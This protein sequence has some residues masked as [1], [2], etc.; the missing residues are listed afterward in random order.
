MD[1]LSTIERMI[2]LLS[3]EGAWTQ[4]ACFRTKGGVSRGVP[5]ERVSRTHSRC[6]YGAMMDACAVKDDDHRRR[7][8][9]NMDQVKEIALWFDKQLERQ[10]L[11]A[12]PFARPH[13]WGSNIVTWNDTQGRTQ[14][15]ILEFLHKCASEAREKDK[16]EHLRRRDELIN[17]EASRT[18]PVPKITTKWFDKAIS[19]AEPELENA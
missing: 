1:Y 17:N 7:V 16:Q 3:P 2:E 13:Q 8:C 12:R 10:S 6:I 15:D 19:K 9:V 14:A 11:T 5:T 4:G 18:L